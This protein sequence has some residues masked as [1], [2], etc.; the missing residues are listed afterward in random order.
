MSRKKRSFT[1]S[2]D[3]AQAQRCPRCGSYPCRCP[4]PKSLPPAEQTAAIRRETKGRGGKQVTVIMDLQLNP[5]ELKKLGKQLKQKCGSGGAVK[6]GSIEIQG[7]HR[8]QIAEELQ[9]MGY[10]TKFVGG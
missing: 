6:D 7:D 8:Q 4:K 9:K 5:E 1:Y 3:S 10:K 2:K